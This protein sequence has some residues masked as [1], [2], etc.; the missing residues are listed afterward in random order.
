VRPLAVNRLAL[1]AGAGALLA[2]DR[3]TR[4]VARF[5]VRF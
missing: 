5:S 1:G 4:I 3:S 2:F